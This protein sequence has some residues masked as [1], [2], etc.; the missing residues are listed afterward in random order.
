MVNRNF[1]AIFYVVS[2][3]LSGATAKLADKNALPL[4][5]LPSSIQLDSVANVNKSDTTCGSLW[6]RDGT[7]CDKAKLID[8]C[9]QESQNITQALN[10]TKATALVIHTYSQIISNDKIMDSNLISVGA[11]T[12][13]RN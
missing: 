9:E 8:H 4:K 13:I 12:I 3:C 5:H 6:N 1:L 11:K 2:L 7:V 10:Y